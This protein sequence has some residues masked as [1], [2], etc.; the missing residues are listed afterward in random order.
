MRVFSSPPATMLYSI[1]STSVAAMILAVMACGEETEASAQD[2]SDGN[3]SVGSRIY[4]LGCTVLLYHSKAL[5][6]LK[7]MQKRICFPLQPVR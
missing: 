1:Q 3:L 2:N 6:S 4:H 7:T 5:F